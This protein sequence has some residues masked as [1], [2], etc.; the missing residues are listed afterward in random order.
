MVFVFD[1]HQS[2]DDQRNSRRRYTRS[3]EDEQQT[4]SGRRT[5]ANGA[6]QQQ[7]RE[8]QYRRHDVIEKFES[9]RVQAS[10][11]FGSIFDSNTRWKRDASYEYGPRDQQPTAG[12]HLGSVSKSEWLVCSAVSISE[13]CAILGIKK[14]LEKY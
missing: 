5:N 12:F 9:K 4:P 14:F 2:T 7:Q 6:G 10:R 13:T 8:Q 11:D 1:L 3:D